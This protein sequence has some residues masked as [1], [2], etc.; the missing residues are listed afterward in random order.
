VPAL[1]AAA[2]A[3]DWAG[4]PPS[5]RRAVGDAGRLTR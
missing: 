3:K 4:L 1:Q 2:P 5:E